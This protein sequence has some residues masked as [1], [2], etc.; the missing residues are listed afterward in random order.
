MMNSG[1]G[2]GAAA[3]GSMGGMNYLTGAFAAAGELIKGRQQRNQIDVQRDIEQF[4]IKAQEQNASLVAQQAGAREEQ[5]RRESRY[6]LG[7]QRAA[8]GQSGVGFGGSSADI[9]R[10]SSAAAE[11]D[12]L[13]IRYAGDIERLGI[14]N[15][16][17]MRKFNDKV[18]KKQ[19]KQAMR[20]RWF[21]AAS[22][23]FGSSG[24]QQQIGTALAKNQA[25]GQGAT[26]TSHGWASGSRGVYGGFGTPTGGRRRI[27]TGPA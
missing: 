8:I 10:Q 19:G 4:N 6:L 11:L 12:A 7:A 22:A 1:A 17:T 18:L 20:L 26:G 23:F 16:I 21:N 24:V 27:G 9:M 2:A 3:G 25:Y 5:Q 14:L 13:N 15:D